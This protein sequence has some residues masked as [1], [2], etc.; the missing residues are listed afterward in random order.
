MFTGVKNGHALCVAV[1][2]LMCYKRDI[3]SFVGLAELACSR[4]DLYY[5]AFKFDFGG[6]GRSGQG[7]SGGIKPDEMRCPFQVQTLIHMG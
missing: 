5:V 6:G 1:L 2:G 3:T 7:A 4:C